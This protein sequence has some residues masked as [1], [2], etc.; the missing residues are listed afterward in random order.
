MHLAFNCSQTSMPNSMLP[1]I[2]PILSIEGE[3]LVKT[4]KFKKPNYLGDP[5]NAIR[6]FNDK[7][8][9]EIAIVDIKASKLNLEP[10]Y[11]MIEEM[12]SQCF[13]PLSYGGGIKSIDQVKKIFD[14][15]VEKII[16]NSSAFLTPKLVNEIA[17]SFGSQSVVASFD[18]KKDFFGNPKINCLSASK[19]VQNTIPY[20]ID[21][22]Q[23]EGVGEILLQD[24]S[25][26]GTFTGVNTSLIEEAKEYVEVP[27]VY[28]GGVRSLDDIK[29]ALKAGAQA[30]A[31]GSFFAYR[32]NDPKSILID[33]PKY[34]EIKR[35]FGNPE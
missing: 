14:L 34:S 32:N 10:N 31:A 27:L 28:V 18:I 25:R 22:L 13:S 23:K 7:M 12:A 8:V 17:T 21:I 11:Q 6:I 4:V 35:Q 5:L 9:D 1:R 30:V 24:V 15:G 2:I 29:L 26:D 19:K 16:L 20:W 33:Y 3:R